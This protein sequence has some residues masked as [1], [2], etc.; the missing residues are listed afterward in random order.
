LLGLPLAQL[1]FPALRQRSQPEREAVR[2]AVSAPIH[3][4]GRISV[5]EYCLSRLLHSELSDSIPPR[6]QWRVDRQAL[7]ANSAAAATLLAV[8]AQ[9]GSPGLA[10]AVRAFQAG[11]GR[12]LPGQH[13][14]YR[15]PA[16][17]WLALESVWSTLDGLRPDD[18]SLLMQAAV[19]V[20]S[21]DGV[22][23]ATEMELLRTICSLLHCPLPPLA[24]LE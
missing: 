22:M 16:Q 15:P 2:G 11:I 12:V 10:G 14:P 7:A 9:V 23:T 13:P 19:D 21:Q 3:A 17:A 8:L 18:K 5:F 20:I 24:G 6:S 1:S 4:D